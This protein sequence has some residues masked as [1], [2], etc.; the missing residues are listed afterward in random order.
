MHNGII[1]GSLEIEKYDTMQSYKLNVELE[2]E[3]LEIDIRFC[4][5]SEYKQPQLF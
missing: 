4:I 5:F 1:P 3:N 2:N